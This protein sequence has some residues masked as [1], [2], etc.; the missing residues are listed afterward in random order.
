MDPIA[1]ELTY[2]FFVAALLDAL[3]I[4]AR[5]EWVQDIPKRVFPNGE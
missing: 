4:K 2:F 1:Q 3:S 5:F